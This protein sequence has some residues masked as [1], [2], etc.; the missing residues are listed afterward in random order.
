MFNLRNC[1]RCI[2]RRASKNCIFFM[3]IV[4]YVL[5]KKSRNKLYLRPHDTYFLFI[6]FFSLVNNI[7]FFHQALTL[8]DNCNII[9]YIIANAYP[10]TDKKMQWP[11]DYL[12]QHINLLIIFIIIILTNNTGPS[13]KKQIVYK[14]LSRPHKH[15]HDRKL[16]NTTQGI[17]QLLTAALNPSN[18]P[19]PSTV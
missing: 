19:V 14:L 13:G 5:Q 17:D 2:F 11:T 1:R 16:K 18:V 8:T 7:F 10:A 3:Q 9:E 4:F 6:M 15:Q 12:N